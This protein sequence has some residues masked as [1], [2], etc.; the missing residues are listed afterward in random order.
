MAGV[1]VHFRDDEPME[2]STVVEHG[3]TR[4][5]D[6]K[7]GKELNRREHGYQKA[8]P[9]PA[10]RIEKKK[11]GVAVHF[12]NDDSMERNT[13]VEHDALSS[14]DEA[15]DKGGKDETKDKDRK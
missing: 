13:V 10:N 2:K 12:R 7:Q 14:G 6:E 1:A 4:K 9:D 11:D 8:S 15:N 5:Q 3:K